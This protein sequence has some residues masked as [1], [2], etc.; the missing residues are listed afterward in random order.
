[1]VW[2]YDGPGGY[3]H[4]WLLGWTGGSGSGKQSGGAKMAGRNQPSS[5]GRMIHDPRQAG[6][7]AVVVPSRIYRDAREAGGASTF[8]K[9]P[10]LPDDAFGNPWLNNDNEI[11]MMN[12]PPEDKARPMDF[13]YLGDAPILSVTDMN[14]K[15][16]GTGDFNKDGHTDLLW[17]YDGPGGYNY[18]WFMNGTTY[19]GA[20]ALASVTDLNW[21]IVGTGDFNNDGHIDILWRYAGAAGY[22]H[23]WFMVG[24]TDGGSRA[25]PSVENMN[26][27]VGGTGDFNGDNKVDILWRYYGAEGYNSVWYMDGWMYAGSACLAAVPDPNWRIEGSADFN[28]DGYADVLWRYYGPGG[29]VKV[30]FLAGTADGG[31]RDLPAVPD[32]NWKIVSR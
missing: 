4:V 25:L 22:V 7:E 27:E 23:V 11:R 18:V 2:R 14:W 32:L 17:R 5:P 10:R 12:P 28:S 13:G 8:E 26:W 9:A 29:Y 21:K 1:M 24:T 3:N 19:I 6:G 16:A 15:I 20:T 30:C 31:V